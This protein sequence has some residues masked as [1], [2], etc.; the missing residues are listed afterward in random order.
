[1]VLGLR[2]KKKLI[3]H[4]YMF[5]TENVSTWLIN[6][7]IQRI[8]TNQ[9]FINFLLLHNKLLQIYWIKTIYTSYLTVSVGQETSHGLNVSST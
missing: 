9:N 4:T 5:R 3:S 6:R 1:M 7:Q 2:G 8:K